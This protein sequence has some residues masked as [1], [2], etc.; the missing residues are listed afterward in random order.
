M[1][2]RNAAKKLET[3]LSA[4]DQVIGAD[5]QSLS[6]QLQTLRQKLFPPEAKKQ[7]RKFSSGEAANLIGVTDSYLRHLSANG[8][9]PDPE[10]TST[11]RRAYTLDQIHALRHHLAKS[12]ASYAVS[13]DGAEHLQII[14]VT[15]FKGGSGKTTTAAHLAQY[16][17]MRGYRILAIDLDPQASMSALFGCQPEFDVGENQTL[18]GAIRYDGG[19]R[20]LPDVIRTTYFAGLDLAPGNLELHEFEH[21]TPKALANPG[22]DP[23]DLFFARVA[24]ALLTVDSRYDVVVIDCPPQLGFLTLS[25]LC[26]ATSV[27]ITVHP[28]MLDVAS[29]N[30]F[31]SMASSL[32]CVVRE[33]G[34]NLQYDWIRYLITRYEPHDGP[35]AQIV[36]FRR[37]LGMT[38]PAGQR[39]QQCNELCCPFLIHP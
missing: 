6:S 19:P 5:A 31:L 4:M 16:F 24:N 2:V 33:A 26:A 25:A 14:A 34:G 9:G 18:Y 35:Q 3:D 28:Q 36:A 13:R 12:R 32:L 23:T 29:M 22:R 10:K 11:G 17:A 7:L 27:L 1:S 8:E 30:Q 20:P 21:E 38:T 15:N 39:Y 37:R